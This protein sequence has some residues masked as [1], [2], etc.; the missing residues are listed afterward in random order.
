MN[1]GRKRVGVE[2]SLRPMLIG[3]CCGIGIVRM[4]MEGGRELVEHHLDCGYTGICV[5]P[6]RLRVK[7]ER[8]GGPGHVVWM[9]REEKSR[10]N[11]VVR[12]NVRLGRCYEWGTS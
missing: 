9:M 10:V 11:E 6:G 3:R 5:L 2:W 7:E 8:E 1:K 12:S 4:Q